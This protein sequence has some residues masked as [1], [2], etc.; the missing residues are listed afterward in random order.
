MLPAY[1]DRREG[2]VQEFGHGPQ[3]HAQVSR[4]FR[5]A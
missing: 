1:T 4:P 2:S 5:L 3:I